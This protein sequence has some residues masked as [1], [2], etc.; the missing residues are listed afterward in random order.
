MGEGFFRARAEARS[1]RRRLCPSCSARVALTSLAAGLL[2][3]LAFSAPAGA[4]IHRGHSFLASLETSGENKLSDAT[5]VAVNEQ[6]SGEGAGD[7]YVLDKGNNRVVRFGPKH[8]FLEAWGVG[9][10][11]GAAY[12]NCK[13][14]AKCKSGV[15]G[16][17]TPSNP[18]F[19]EPVAIA[20]DN[21]PSGGKGSP[22]SGD[23][24]VVGNR[25]W[26][27]A[28]IYKFNFEGKPVD[29][30]VDRPEER[31]EAWPIDGVTVDKTGVVWV[32][33]EA[34]EEEVVIERFNNEVKNKIIDEPEEFELPEVTSSRPV[35]PG[36]AIDSLGHAYVTYEPNGVDIEE[37]EELFEER[38]EQRHEQ[39]EPPVEEHIQTPCVQNACFVAQFNVSVGAEG[40]LEGE[41]AKSEAEQNTT[42]LAVDPSIGAQSSNDL[43]LD[44]ATSVSAFTSSGT[45]IQTF[46]QAQLA[47]GGGSGLAVNG[48]SNEIFVADRKLARVDIFGPVPPGPAVIQEGS[49][50]AANVTANSAKFK[51]TIDPT[52]NDTRYFFRY[53]PGLCSSGACT[54]ATPSVDIGGGFGD[55][56]ASAEVLGLEPSTAYHFV[57]VAVSEPE[58]K[59]SEVVSAEEGAVTTLA[60]NTLESVL[61]DGR[62]WELVSPEDKRGVAV[63]PLSHE[64][65]LIEAAA[66][67]GAFAFVAAAP[68]GTEEPPGNRAPEL[69]QFIATRSSAGSWGTHNITTPNLS[70]QGVL[71]GTRREYEA[72]SSDLSLAGLFPIE[73][74][75]ATETTESSSGLQVYVRNTVCRAPARCY[76]PLTQTS[77]AAAGKSPL[78]AMT[79]NLKHVGLN[80]GPN[81]LLE[82]SAEE[83]SP[84]EG[85]VRTVNI[86]PSGATATGE[87]GFGAPESEVNAGARNAISSDGTRVAWAQRFSTLEGLN[88]HLYQTIFS[89][90][91]PE[92]TQVD[93]PNEEAGIPASNV[94]PQAVYMT[95]STTGD[96]LFFTDNQPLTKAASKPSQ[97]TGD[98]YVYEH[99]KPVGERLTDLTPDLNAGESSTVLGG[100]IGASEDG[101]YVYFVANGV[102]A[103]GASPGTC[104]WG[105]VRTAKCNLYMVHNNGSEWEKPHF[106]A[107]LSNEDGPDWSAENKGRVNYRIVEMTAR[108]SPDG[109]FL[110]FMSDQRLTGYNNLDANS[111]EPDEEVYLFDASS[112]KV[113][114]ASC[115]PTG[116]EPIGV[117]DVQESGEGR[118]LLVDRLGLWSTETEETANAHWLAASVPGWTNLDDHESLY[119]S[120]YLSNEG[121]LFFNASDT[122]VKQDVNGKEDVYQYEPIGVGGCASENTTGGCVALISSGK[123]EQ[124]STFLDASESG[125]DVFFLTSSPLVPAHDTDK[126]FDIY[127]ARICNVAGAEEACPPTALAPAAPCSGEE[128]RAAPTPQP[129]YGPPSN[130]GSSGSGNVTQQTSVLGS[131]Q[132][133]KAKVQTRAQKLAAALKTC[134]KKYKKSKRKRAAC[135]KQARKKYGAK[136]SSPSKKTAAKSSTKAGR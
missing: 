7:I 122:L 107:R 72:F 24:Y 96:R 15:A 135:E 6:T 61:P 23:V 104:V 29:R 78:N 54:K 100:V 18:Q 76:Q 69:S 105:G 128:C 42:G 123:S 65:G 35:R 88:Q 57:V 108:T 12:E 31:E 58:G 62:A 16:F 110:S 10:G 9:V 73:A 113:V 117:H 136:K 11:G 27:K 63:E 30:L 92:P 120:R 130:S 114:C 43:Y 134:K 60:A 53:G 74:L 87:I 115:N 83:A 39:K 28:V 131:K 49:V 90:G 40:R 67:G 52:G 46:G 129:T 97:F 81:S 50:S 66:G 48:A 121:R 68:V 3:L 85:H 89:N 59:A 34:G 21:A 119:Q 82:W 32:D 80:F 51:A 86:L 79:T 19:D 45:L 94:A 4:F 127:D 55:Q 84:G 98:L 103:E 17:G 116:A 132:T 70:A 20:V 106:I 38:A 8:E 2:A 22:S 126:A 44:N 64:G 111:G 41:F 26:K 101:S 91:T 77:P 99:A 102:L 1:P 75:A 124:E 25:S 37:E 47:E 109:H 5:A 118:N 56:S 125:G 33:R 93:E 112:G 95:S 133:Q 36:F 71:A 13:E 14:A